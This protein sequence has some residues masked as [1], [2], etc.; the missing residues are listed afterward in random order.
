MKRLVA[1]AAL[2]LV[3]GLA[4]GDEPRAVEL[5][6]AHKCYVC[7]ANDETLVGPAFADVATAYRGDPDAA[8]KIAT[9]IR[10]GGSSGGPWH[11]PPHPEISPADATTIARYI[12]SLDPEGRSSG[13]ELCR[14]GVSMRAPRRHAADGGDE[15]WR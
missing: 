12:L 6:R 11:M 8:A 14:P 10:R 9:F 15:Q 2:A 3:A 5:A 7:H 1:L 4:Q 13:S